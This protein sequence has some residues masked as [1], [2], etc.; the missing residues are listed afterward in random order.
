VEIV[1]RRKTQIM[2]EECRGTEKYAEERKTDL[3]ILAE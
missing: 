3:K 2:G 1:K